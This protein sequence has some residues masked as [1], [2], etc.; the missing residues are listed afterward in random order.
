MPHIF[1]ETSCSSEISSHFDKSLL[2]GLSPSIDGDV[3]LYSNDSLPSSNDGIER[4]SESSW[5]SQNKVKEEANQNANATNPHEDSS[6]SNSS[7]SLAQYPNRDASHSTSYS[8][9][10]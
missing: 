2:P 1:N 4:V 3:E 5:T 9:E 8:A 7:N 10:H 6:D